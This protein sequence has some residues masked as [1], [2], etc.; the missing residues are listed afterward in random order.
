MIADTSLADDRKLEHRHTSF[1]P[2]EQDY[3]A[4]GKA[5]KGLLIKS[6]DDAAATSGKV[7]E[8]TSGKIA[9]RV[10]YRAHF[11]NARTSASRLPLGQSPGLGEVPALVRVLAYHKANKS[12]ILKLLLRCRRPA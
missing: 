8:N 12:P 2:G 10:D 4:N 11:G 9:A 6:D 7:A 3:G 1:A 5:I